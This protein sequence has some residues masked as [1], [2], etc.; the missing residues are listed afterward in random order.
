MIGAI[1]GDIAGSRFEFNNHRSKEFELFTD[2]CEATDDSIMTLA[3]AKAI[4]ETDK[5]KARSDSG[6]EQ[7]SDY[8]TLLSK[9]TVKYMQ[10][11]GRQNPH[12]GYGGSFARWVISDN[13]KPYNSYGNGAAMRISPAGYAAR[14]EEEA[15]KLS[16]SITRVTHNHPEG[17]KG[18]EAVA[19]AIFM[20][21]RGSTRKEIRD[22]I[23]SSYYPM[24]FTADAIRDTYEFNETCQDTVPQAIEAFLESTSFEDAIRTA[25]SIGGDSD[26]VA[27][28]TGSIAE[29]YYGVPEDIRNKAL[30]YLDDDLRAIYDKWSVFAVTY[31]VSRF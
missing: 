9:M 13:P 21:R 31:S 18:A 3:V 24:N 19:V 12:C 4:M 8:Y 30:E 16:L 28:I 17:I 7:D 20:A 14:T 22:K 5:A 15:V 10:E 1:I 26:T 11:I 2:D 27:A 6:S 25:I 23:D 29:A